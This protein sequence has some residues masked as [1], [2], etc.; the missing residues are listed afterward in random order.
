MKLPTLRRGGEALDRRTHVTGNR[1]LAVGLLLPDH[2]RQFDG[3]TARWRDLLEMARLGEGI[4]AD[5]IWVTDHLLHRAPDEEPRGAWECW[6]HLSA[7]AAVTSRVELG[8]LVVCS[9]FRNPSLLAKM[10]DTVEEI[11]DG[12]LILGIGAGWNEAEFRAFGYPFEHRVSRFAEALAIIS[13]LLRD[14]QI[15]F[16]GTYYQARDCELRPRGPRPQGPPILIGSIA[17]R[18]LELLARYGDAWNVWWTNTGNRSEGVP[19]VAAKVDEACLAIGRDPATMAKTV[20]VLVAVGPARP[21]PKGVAPLSG[22]PEAIAAGL[23]AYADVGVSHLQVRLQ[24]NVPASW[25]RFGLVL[26]A[27]DRG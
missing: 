3:G 8:T 26:E 2:E 5:S 14:G 1:P 24:P 9:G 19:A 10:A 23:R 25:E 22:T 11:S 6:S 21:A 15:D 20:S 27:L 18:M 16:D 4:G 13:G 7:L 17:P 12:R